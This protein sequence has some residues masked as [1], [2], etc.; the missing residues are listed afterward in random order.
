MCVSLATKSV[1]MNWSKNKYILTHTHLYIYIYI[2][3]YICVCVCGGLYVCVSL[4]KAC[5]L[6]IK[7]SENVY[8]YQKGSFDWKGKTRETFYLGPALVCKLDCVRID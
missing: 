1:N 6:L 7:G 2:Y 5:E 4:I 3:I 8:W